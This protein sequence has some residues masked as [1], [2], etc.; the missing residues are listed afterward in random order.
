MANMLA[1]SDSEF[2]SI[3]Y[4]IKLIF[5]INNSLQFSG[6]YTSRNT[7]LDE[8]NFLDIELKPN[9]MKLLAP[10][11]DTEE[12]YLQKQKKRKEKELT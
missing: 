11:H 5:V 3:L 6:K 8:L 1:N 7:I 4:S 2:L 9:N 10:L 12:K